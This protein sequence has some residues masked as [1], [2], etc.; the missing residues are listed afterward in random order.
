MEAGA[1]CVQTPSVEILFGLLG[2]MCCLVLPA[3]VLSAPLSFVGVRAIRARPERRAAWIVGLAL[4]NALV[5]GFSLAAA[6]VVTGM[7][8]ASE[9]A[10][11]ILSWLVCAG[12]G[13]GL[14]SGFAV[15]A[16]ILS[17][18]TRAGRAS[19][20][21]APQMPPPVDEG[22][23]LR[24][25]QR[26]CIA[27]TVLFFVGVA[28]SLVGT[29]LAFSLG[30]ISL[31]VA[32]VSVRPIAIAFVLAHLLAAAVAGTLY[33]GGPSRRRTALAGAAMSLFGAFMAGLIAAFAPSVFEELTSMAARALS[34]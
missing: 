15:T 26:V 33:G 8:I 19:A 13:G 5:S 11:A 1:R 4:L 17:V 18:A 27:T 29:V 2:A 21:D 20:G 6:G 25:A 12:C 31:G 32:Y 7:S 16:I 30:L 3:L 10:G 22:R 28:T 34:R 14:I 23:L 9:D 24:R